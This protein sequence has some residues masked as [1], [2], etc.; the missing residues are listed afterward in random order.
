GHQDRQEEQGSLQ[1]EDLR[2]ASDRSGLALRREV[3]AS[4]AQSEQGQLQAPCDPPSTA[5]T[6]LEEDLEGAPWPPRA[7][8]APR[9]AGRS[10]L[11]VS[12]NKARHVLRE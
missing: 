11:S 10:R 9:A 12:C 5:G 3:W 1:G 6:D 7:L 8:S 2:L 4:G